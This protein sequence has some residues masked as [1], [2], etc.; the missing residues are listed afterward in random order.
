MGRWWAWVLLLAVAAR[1]DL[2]DLYAL[3]AGA[4]CID[5]YSGRPDNMAG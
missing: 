5:A 2:Q 4:P 1:R 3:Y